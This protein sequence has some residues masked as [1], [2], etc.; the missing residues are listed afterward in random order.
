MKSHSRGT[1]TPA[2][3]VKG[4]REVCGSH[5]GTPPKVPLK[6]DKD[7]CGS[8]QEENEALP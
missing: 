5:M 4:D 3:P 2:V 6:G 7:I 8:S 1:K